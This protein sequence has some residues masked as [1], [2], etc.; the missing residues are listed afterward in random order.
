MEAESKE[1]INLINNNEYYYY[2]WKKIIAL[3]LKINIMKMLMIY[4]G[5]SYLLK[6]HMQNK[7]IN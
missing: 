3:I 7:L 6:I 1:K 2:K 5:Q 4:F